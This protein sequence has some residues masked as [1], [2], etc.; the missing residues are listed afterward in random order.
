[1]LVCR[2][3]GTV[4]ICLKID[5]C[6]Q[7]LHTNLYV[8]FIF[9]LLKYISNQ[10]VIETIISYNTVVGDTQYINFLKIFL[11]KMDIFFQQ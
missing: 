2:L 7:E 4:Y 1:M 11:K 5:T 8:I 9:H 3:P 10:F 6:T